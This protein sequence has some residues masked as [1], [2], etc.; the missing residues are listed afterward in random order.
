MTDPGPGDDEVAR[1]LRAAGAAEEPMPADV[2]AR[3]DQRLTEL[4]AERG[5]AAAQGE[6]VPLST[7]GRRRA[8][9]GGVLAAAA[10][11]VGGYGLTALLGETSLSGSAGEASVAESADEAPAAGEAEQDLAGDGAA[12]EVGTRGAVDDLPAL[13]STSLADDVERLLEQT[14]PDL[15]GRV[16]D[17]D[18][19][20]PGCRP[21]GRPGA[22]AWYAVRYDGRRALLLVTQRDAGAD[23]ALVY[24]CA[25]RLLDRAVVG[26]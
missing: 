13:R 24:T 4:V 17:T 6:V 5:E 1:L 8:W 25:G 18:A 15:G 20:Q 19:Y 22:G 7:R 10:V 2:A 11:V 9:A 3:L 26:R 23:Q 21:P 16:P 12:P 14:E